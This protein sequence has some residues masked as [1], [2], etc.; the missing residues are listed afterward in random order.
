MPVSFNDKIFK[1]AQ[2]YDLKKDIIKIIGELLE[3]YTARETGFRILC[4]S[5]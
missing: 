2:L 1:D 3:F 4:G 5:I